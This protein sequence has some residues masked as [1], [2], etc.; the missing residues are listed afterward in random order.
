MASASRRGAELVSH[1]RVPLRYP[2]LAWLLAEFGR[3]LRYRYLHYD[4][5][6]LG[7]D[8][9]Y[10]LASC[11]ANG[12]SDGLFAATTTKGVAYDPTYY[13]NRAGNIAAVQLT[14]VTV[15][16]SKNNIISRASPTLSLVLRSAHIF[17]SSVLTGI[18][19]EHVW[20]FHSRCRCIRKLTCSGH[21]VKL[22]ASHVCPCALHS[23]VAACWGSGQSVTP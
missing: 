4:Y 19:T 22:L 8:Q 1:G 18:N 14:L 20:L 2:S 15:L 9:Q 23:S 21:L 12:H 11:L 13:A 10:V 16:G 5:L 17:G 3:G 6:C 7:D